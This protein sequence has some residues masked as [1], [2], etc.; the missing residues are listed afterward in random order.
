[1]TATLMPACAPVVRAPPE[2]TVA[3][4]AVAAAV[5]A[6]EVATAVAAAV[7]AAVAVEVAVALLTV[8]TVDATGLSEPSGHASHTDAPAPLNVL[9]GQ[10]LAVAFVEPALQK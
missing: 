4:A 6:A 2:Y 5:A 10:A 1:M 9:R 7:E 8:H 3:A